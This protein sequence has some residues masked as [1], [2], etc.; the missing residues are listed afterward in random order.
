M[1]FAPLRPERNF[2]FTASI[3]S[4]AEGKGQS[5]AANRLQRVE[6]HHADSNVER[7]PQNQS[8]TGVSTCIG[9]RASAQ[10]QLP[11]TSHHM[12]ERGTERFMHRQPVETTMKRLVLVLG[13]GLM[14]RIESTADPWSICAAVQMR[15]RRSR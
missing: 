4:R 13:R 6:G 2:S 7:S 15:R 10:T 5:E 9:L 1:Q 14:H 3:P 8:E 12:V 11:S